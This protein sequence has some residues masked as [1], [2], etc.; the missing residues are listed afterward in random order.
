MLAEFLAIGDRAGTQSAVVRVSG[1]GSILEG[2]GFGLVGR[3]FF[4]ANSTDGAN[5]FLVVENGGLYS[6]LNNLTI[7]TG[8]TLSGNGER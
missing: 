4:D 3:N 6:T 7:S 8:G 5:A 1:V 2:V